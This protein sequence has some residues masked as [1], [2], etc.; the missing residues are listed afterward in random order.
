MSILKEHWNPHKY[1]DKP[2]CGEK[3]WQVIAIGFSQ[4]ST[5]TCEKCLKIM[6]KMER[7]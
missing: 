2:V 1:A 7:K 6:S 3:R 5:V 4:S